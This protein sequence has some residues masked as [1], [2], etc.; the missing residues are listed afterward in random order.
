MHTIYTSIGRAGC[1]YMRESTPFLELG[2][3]S[4]S[5]L[6]RPSTSEL[7]CPDV[8]CL[9]DDHISGPESPCLFYPSLWLFIS[10]VLHTYGGSAMLLPTVGHGMIAPC[11]KDKKLGWLPTSNRYCPLEV[12]QYMSWKPRLIYFWTRECRVRWAN[13]WASGCKSELS[14]YETSTLESMKYIL[15]SRR[16]TGSRTLNLLLAYQHEQML[17]S[18]S[19][20]M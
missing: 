10:K 14:T 7:G 18:K 8:G 1:K 13:D 17:K 5:A 11:G 3:R 12:N 2:P 4:S 19:F 15:P 6:D 16:D 9:P 20:K